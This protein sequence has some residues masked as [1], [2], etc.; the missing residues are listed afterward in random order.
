MQRLRRL[1]SGTFVVVYLTFQVVYPAL[2]W[3][4][5]GFSTFTWHM[6]AGL[7]ETPRFVVSFA[8]GSTRD[9]GV[10]LRRNNPV[11]LFGPSVDQARFVP[12]HLC[13]LW[14]GARE[15]HLLY[16]RPSRELTV[17]CP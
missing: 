14:T 6:Y 4:F 12:A 13:S 5:P 1:A 15:V 10:L 17:P 8:D 11:R 16:R 7:E 3:F 9:A 2:P